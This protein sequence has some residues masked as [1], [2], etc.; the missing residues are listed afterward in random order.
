MGGED[1]GEGDEGGGGVGDDDHL[2]ATSNV[3]F[4][5]SPQSLH[6][7]SQLLSNLHIGL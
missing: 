6:L 3:L 7:S 5:S 4:Q 1:D 2:T